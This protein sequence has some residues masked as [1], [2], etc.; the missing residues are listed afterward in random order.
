MKNYELRQMGSPERQNLL[1]E[2]KKELLR[3]NTQISTGA[4]PE[5]PG[6]ARQVKKTIAKI[7]TLESSNRI[8][9]KNTEGGKSNNG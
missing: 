3:I 8:G 6:R 5:N 4:A 7:L 2:M 9:K 1:K